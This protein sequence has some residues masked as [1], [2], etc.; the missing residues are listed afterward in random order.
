MQAD[1]K[2][3]ISTAIDNTAAEE[4]LKDLVNLTKENAEIIGDK[5]TNSVSRVAAE[6]NSWVAKQEEVNA[7]AEK[8]KQILDEMVRKQAELT[9]SGTK[10]D[11]KKALEIAP[12]I[13][14]AQA[15]YNKLVAQSDLYLIKMNEAKIKANDLAMEIEEVASGTQKASSETE[16]L[17][18]KTKKS[19]ENTSKLVKNFDLASA[20]ATAM[21]KASDVSDSVNRG[22]KSI[23]K[24]A[25]A[26]FSIRTIYS[27]MTRAAN[28]FLSSNSKVGNQIKSNI[29]YMWNALGNLLAPVLQFITNLMYSLLSM[30]N[31]ILMT[32]FGIN[33]FANAVADS[34]SNAAGGLADANEEAKKLKKQLA[35]FDEMN[36]LQGQDDSSSGGS[37]GGGGGSAVAPSFDTTFFDDL[38]KDLKKQFG[39]F[40]S[41][42]TEDM[43]FGPLK[44]SINDLLS[45]FKYLGQGIQEVGG[46]FISDFVKPLSTYVINDTLPNFLNLTAEAI[47]GISFAKL[48]QGLGALY[49]A[50]LPFTKNILDGLLWFY[51]KILI[52]LGLWVINEAVPAFLKLIATGI[53]VVNSAIDAVKPMFSWLWDNMLSPLAKWTGQVFIAALK[54]ITSV[55]NGVS[56]WIKNNQTLFSAMVATLGIFFAAWK[57]ANL[58]SFVKEAGGV[59]K[60]I[61]SLNSG[62]KGFGKI[63]NSEIISNLRLGITWLKD[64]VVHFGKEVIAANL[65]TVA[66]KAKS[67]AENLKAKAVALSTTATGANTVAT[68]AQ[69][70]AL[71]IGAIAAKAFGAAIT[72][73]TSPLGI[74]VVAV[75]ALVGVVALLTNGFGSAS[76]EMSAAEKKQEMLNEKFEESKAIIETVDTS[77]SKLADETLPKLRTEWDDLQV[78]LSKYEFT[79]NADDLKN[80]ATDTEEYLSII[81]ESTSSYYDNIYTD[82][83]NYYSKSSVLT[84][85]EEQEI[86]KKIIEAQGEKET[87]IAEHEAALLEL[88]NTLEEKGELNADEQAQYQEH[89]NALNTIAIETITPEQA[90]QIA[91]Q[92]AFI[93]RKGKLSEDE[94][95]KFAE[96]LRTSEADKLVTLQT[97]YGQEYAALEEKNRLINMDEEQYEKEKKDIYDRMYADIESNTTEHYNKLL[98]GV[99]GYTADEILEYRRL[100]AEEQSLRGAAL[101]NQGTDQEKEYTQLA[102]SLKK[103]RE[104][105]G[106]NADD[107]SNITDT[108]SE[109]E[110]EAYQKMWDANEEETRKGA[111]DVKKLVSR[112]SSDFKTEGSNKIRNQR[113]GFHAAGKYATE[114]TTAGINE[115]RS[116]AIGAMYSLATDILKT[117]KDKLEIHSPSRAMRR[118]LKW[119][120]IGGAMG[121][122]DEEGTLINATDNMIDGV[123]DS[124]SNLSSKFVEVGNEAMSELENTLDKQLNSEIDVSANGKIA[125]VFSKVADAITNGIDKLIETPLKI[126]EMS[127]IPS[128]SLNGITNIP[129][130]SI[131]F[132]NSISSKYEDVGSI[133]N[134]LKELM[135]NKDNSSADQAINLYVDGERLFKWIIKKKKE[136]EFAM[137]GG[138]I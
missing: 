119:V 47:R 85:T 57:V 89:L 17:S 105:M 74:A 22:I 72:F 87:S 28:N 27:T 37:S 97:S 88:Q 116:A 51:E 69:T 130:A 103:K 70:A 11:S 78:A 115:G 7:K 82:A 39:E 91:E 26:L 40:F 129:K 66:T 59:T 25:A 2:I 43:N 32:F 14:K 5:L 104:A 19:N 73:F 18:D 38:F 23:A 3:R 99:S 41:W 68:T 112:L 96:S 9:A 33:I 29:D 67:L 131:P 123:I 48:N 44:A 13:E 4:D 110:N 90:R 63:W 24:I 128:L 125:N 60:A 108:L 136:K 56:S 121:I 100:E 45:T 12:D 71:N 134:T 113:P 50:L 107:I 6:Y 10:S 93:A 86:L 94:R 98:E 122:K 35:G 83:L 124:A 102:N 54:G 46:K 36:V 81:K 95:I 53:N 1:G 133:E 77:Y 126:A 92:E 55:L 135:L 34:T 137:N 8:Q 49:D 75:T 101:R 21:N 64:S 109:D 111:E 79:S 118:L 117:A 42:F 30:L 20:K 106:I 127:N 76:K 80:L 62:A 138:T 52:P 84:E 31:T 58:I 15:T 61:V 16:K 65:S 132:E 114:G 120:P